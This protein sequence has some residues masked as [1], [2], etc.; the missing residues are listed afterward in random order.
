MGDRTSDTSISTIRDGVST[1]NTP[2]SDSSTQTK[3]PPERRPLHYA[4]PPESTLPTYRDVSN[5]P[6]ITRSTHPSKRS[7]MH[8]RPLNA[9]D[10][11]TTDHHLATD[12]STPT[13]RP[14]SADTD[15]HR[16]HQP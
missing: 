16:D 8:Q 11:H 4:G 6:P 12:Y 15:K 13:Y 9:T 14:H 2:V 1:S 3:P 7:S 10:T 5:T